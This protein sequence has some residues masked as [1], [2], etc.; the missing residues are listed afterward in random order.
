MGTGA[1]RRDD[2]EFLGRESRHDISGTANTRQAVRL[3]TDCSD[4]LRKISDMEDG[5]Q[6]GKRAEIAMLLYEMIVVVAPHGL[7]A[8]HLVCL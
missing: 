6:E 8:N 7:H 5:V 1:A 4:G 2:T 3:R